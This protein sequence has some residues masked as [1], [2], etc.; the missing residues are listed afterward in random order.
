MISSGNNEVNMS[1]QLE[2]RLADGAHRETFATEINA[3][4]H[5]LQGQMKNGCKNAVETAHG[6]ENGEQVKP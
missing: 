6:T 3:A 2:T 4:D 1:A 5:S